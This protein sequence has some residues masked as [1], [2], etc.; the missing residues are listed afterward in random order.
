VKSCGLGLHQPTQ[1]PALTRSELDNATT[2]ESRT[3]SKNTKNNKMLQVLRDL[4]QVRREAASL[5]DKPQESENVDLLCL[6]TTPCECPMLCGVLRAV[7]IDSS[8]RILPTIG[9]TLLRVTKVEFDSDPPQTQFNFQLNPSHL[10]PCVDQ[11]SVRNL[12]E[13]DVSLNVSLERDALARVSSY[14][15][16]VRIVTVDG[17]FN[18]IEDVIRCSFWMSPL[19]EMPSCPSSI[20][21]SLRWL[22]FSFVATFVWKDAGWCFCDPVSAIQVHSTCVKGDD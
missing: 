17:K 22:C 6:R 21:F 19:S 15:R 10:V 7:V 12:E 8:Q 20:V 3:Q 1:L 4:E 14:P 16:V 13:V 9:Q 18:K 5:P 2:L 11:F